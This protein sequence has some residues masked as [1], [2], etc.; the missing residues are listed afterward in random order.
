MKIR[1]LSALIA[2]CLAIPAANAAIIPVNLDADGSGLNDTTA[3]APEG[4]NPGTTVGEQRRI[5]YQFAADLWGSVLTTDVD[6]KVGASFSALTCDSS[7]AVLGSAGTY[8]IWWDNSFPIPGAWYHQALANQLAGVNLM[9]DQDPE[10]Y[11]DAPYEIL[12][13]FN[14]N[15]G[16]TGC[17]D[18][19]GWYYGLD[20][21]TPAGE[22]NFLDVVMHEIG[23][24]LGFSG[25]MNKNTGGLANY[26]GTPRSDAYTHFAYDNVTG[27]RFDDASMT[28]AL[29]KT[30]ITTQG[31][32]A[33]DG[34]NAKAQAPEFLGPKTALQISGSLTANYQFYGSANFGPAATAANFDGDLVIVNDGAGTDT[35]DACEAIAAGSLT[36]KVAFVNRGTCGFEAKTVNAQNAGAIA[37]IIGNVASSSSPGTAPGM[38]DDATLTATIPALSLNLADAN[39]IRTQATGMHVGFGEVAGGYAGADD[40]NRPLLYAPSTVA[41]GSTFS[42]F[43]VSLSPDALM[44]PFSSDDTAANFRLDLTPAVFEDEGWVLRSGTAKLGSK[45]CDTKIDLLTNPG[46]IAGAN[47]EAADNLCTAAYST[48]TGRK[49]CLDGFA[50]R[51]RA[52]GMI[53]SAQQTTI[54]MCSLRR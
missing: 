12:S 47:L 20:G 4:G 43:D 6:V 24:G 53:T 14:A 44:E 49:S 37:V 1:L 18:G 2:G 28:N 16:Q 52:A 34:D 32:A 48:T 29:R 7:S 3:R 30:S 38:A 39:A 36:G 8:W 23:H 42:H 50:K 21:N 45:D 19:S 51:L 15:L 54:A 25:F 13:Q 40:A 17:L 41:S 10:D 46:L 35:A 11:A 26:D 33:W 9:E 31:R 27:A 5:V 22:I